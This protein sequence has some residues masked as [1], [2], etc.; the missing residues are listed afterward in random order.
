MQHVC[1]IFHGKRKYVYLG[2]IKSKIDWGYAKE[3][4]EYAWKI[5]QRKKPDFYVI[6]TG[7]NNSVEYF[8]KK[9]FEHVGLNYKKYTKIDKKLFRPSKT[10]NLLADTLKAKKDLNFNPKTNLDGLIKIMMNDELN[11]Y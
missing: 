7:K 3:Y 5:M 4:V 11:K 10:R 6:G 1:E 9:C 2:N 8:V